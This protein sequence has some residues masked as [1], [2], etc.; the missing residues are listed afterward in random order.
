MHALYRYT[1]VLLFVLLSTAQA[2]AQNHFKTVGKLD[3]FQW[4]PPTYTT[5][6]KYDIFYYIPKSVAQNPSKLTKSMMFMH[7]GGS[8]TMTREG[9][10]YTVKM[11][12]PDFMKIAEDQNMILVLPSTNGLNWGGHTRV[13]LREL[14]KLMRQELTLDPN[15]IAMIGHSMGGMGITRNAFFLGD[16]FAFAMPVAAGMDPK[17]MTNINLLTFFNFPYHH[18]QGLHDHFTEF[19]TRAKLHE[20]KMQELERRM[21]ITS[22]F[23]LTL[24]NTDHNYDLAELNQLIKT[25]FVKSKR[26]LYQKNLYGS[27][28]YANQIITD[29]NIQY[30]YTS[31]PQYFWLEAV[32][33]TPLPQ[34]TR[35]QVEA[36]IVG[37]QINI[38]LIGQ[39]NVKKLRVYISSKMVSLSAPV[40]IT[41]NGVSKFKGMITPSTTVESQIKNSKSDAGY[42][43]EQFV[44]LDVPMTKA[45]A[46]KVK[47]MQKTKV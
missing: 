35:S 42:S 17:Y 13:L 45:T 1:S 21:G 5:G 27:F 39:H 14:A 31:T 28:L 12:A 2:F 43:F 46:K 11:Y 30:N 23:D 25:Q 41:L 34:A 7:G 22:P 37:N 20:Q 18:V 29:N 36:H 32:E 26:N 38:K 47:A 4:S 6:F 15:G 8:S 10:I 33:F 3:S 40:E 19:V 24:T 44:D 16:Q 9:A